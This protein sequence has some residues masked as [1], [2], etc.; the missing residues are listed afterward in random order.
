MAIIIVK[1]NDT[2]KEY[3]IARFLSNIPVFF[4]KELK[5]ATFNI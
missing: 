3:I 5:L 2:V 4:P 1:P